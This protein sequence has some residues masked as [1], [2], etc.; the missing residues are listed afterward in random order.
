[1]LPCV[2]S[3]EAF[4]ILFLLTDWIA[5]CRSKK[6]VLLCTNSKETMYLCRNKTYF[7]EQL[8]FIVLAV[9]IIFALLYKWK[10]RTE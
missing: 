10:K 6:I 4:F 7:M 2:R 3:M 1:M 8:L 9:V 5:N